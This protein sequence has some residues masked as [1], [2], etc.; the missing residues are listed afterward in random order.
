MV[1]RCDFAR[2]SLG[3]A[4]FDRARFEGCDF[5]D[6]DLTDAVTEGAVFRNCRF[7]GASGIPYAAVAADFLPTPDAR[8]PLEARVGETLWRIR[9]NEFP[10][11]PTPYSLLIADEIVAD[12][13]EWPQNWT[14]HGAETQ[15]DDAHEAGQFQLEQAHH[16]RT[17]S[18]PPSKRVK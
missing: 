1:T 12:L 7:D 5:R 3:R 13:M 17:R 2:A 14:R 18:I 4:R 8:Y 10:E 16:E 9:V 15:H 11:E 6:A